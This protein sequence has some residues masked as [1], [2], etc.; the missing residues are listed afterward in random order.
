MPNNSSHAD[1]SPL[2]NPL[3][4]AL[5]VD[6]ADECLNLAHTLKDVA[7]GFK[8]G[9]RLIVRYGEE[10]VKSCAS[11]APVFI[12]L[13][14]LD[15]PSTMETSVRASF[16][17]GASLVTVHAWSGS[18]ALKRLAKLEKELNTQRPF[19][20]LV[21]T[22]LTSFNTSFNEHTMVPDSAIEAEA[23]VPLTSQTSS[24]VSSS[25]A[26]TMKNLPLSEQ[27]ITLADFAS[28]CGLKSFV[29]SAQESTL[30][31]Q[32]HKDSFIVTPGI[33]FADENPSDQKRIQDPKQAI[34]NGASAIVV[35]R[36]IVQAPDPLTQAQKYLHSTTKLL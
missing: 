36:P 3:I 31:R 14:F 13:K 25:M 21:V 9:P 12:D 23:T 4:I 11:L 17:S 18:E 7:G 26:P 1:V 19:K 20:I 30:I 10:I 24:M 35:G 34:Q 33:R 29:C 27:V 8:L 22:I 5:D 28:D 6:T 16:A 32:K 2:K 15:I